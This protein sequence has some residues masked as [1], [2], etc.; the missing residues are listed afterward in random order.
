MRKF[1]LA[2]RIAEV[3]RELNQR[4]RVYPRLIA[5]RELRESEANLRMAIMLDVLDTLVWLREHE[6][7]IVA[8][9]TAK[10]DRAA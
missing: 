4:N 7:E 9:L 5:K 2:S 10:N 6:E 8:F 3:R 1:S